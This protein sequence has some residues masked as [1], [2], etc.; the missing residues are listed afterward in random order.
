M[1]SEKIKKY[2]GRGSGVCVRV[3]ANEKVR[4]VVRK[5]FEIYLE[6]MWS[7][8]LDF[9]EFLKIILYNLHQILHQSLLIIELFFFQ[10]K[11][12][13]FKKFNF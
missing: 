10:L 7:A 3:V 8:D 1:T 11:L 5:E 12:K 4:T 2:R 6:L 13:T 9:E